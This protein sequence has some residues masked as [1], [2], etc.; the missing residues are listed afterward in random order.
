MAKDTILMPEIDSVSAA[1]EDQM[2]DAEA[3]RRSRRQRQS[4]GRSSTGRLPPH[5]LQMEMGVLGCALLD[6]NQCIGECI[7]KLKDDG[8]SAFYD[9]RHQTIYE[10]LAEMFNARMPVDLITVQ[11]NLK[12]RQ[13]LEQVGGIAYLS[14]LQDAVPSAANLSYYLEKIREKYLLRKLIQTCSGV[15]GR[16]YDYEGDV[17]E[18]VDS[19]EKEILGI[20]ESVS[21]EADLVDIRAVQQ[22]VIGQY[23]A[24]FN[25][26]QHFGLQTGFQDL[27][28]LI[29]G[30]LGQEMI[31]VGGSPSSGKTSLALCMMSHLAVNQRVPIGYFSLDDPA[32]TVIHRLACIDAR[33]NGAEIRRGRPTEGDM[34]KLGVA[35]LKIN[36][37][38]DCLMIDESGGLNEFTMHAKARRM[39]QRGAKIIFLDYLQLFQAKGEIYERTTAASHAVKRLAKE[40]NVPVVCISAITKPRDASANWHPKM[41]DFRGSGDIEYDMN[42]AWL[43][44]R[45]PEDMA[46]EFAPIYRVCLDVGKNKQGPT[47]RIKLVFA[48]NCTRFESCSNFEGDVPQR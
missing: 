47:G 48:K 5:D 11:Q 20:R 41:S 26:N 31:M 42:Q 15:V 21:R 34:Q 35:M 25:G 4:H 32:D 6:P 24:A 30:M 38:K 18:L 28:N 27:D 45:D 16:I 2:A 19:V 22:R 36:A 9:L 10:T 12:D 37:A 8:K 29:G 3:T 43:L 40:A 33:V 14:Q 7:E 39:I 17:D 46:D 13:L 44:Y 1:A 23:E